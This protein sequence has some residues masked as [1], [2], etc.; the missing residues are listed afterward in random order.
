LGI[1]CTVNPA[2]GKEEAW[3]ITPPPLQKK[4]LV[5]GAGPAGLEAARVLTL[6]GHKVILYEKEGSLGGQL[7]LAWVP[8]YKKE[9]KRLLDYYQRQI[10]KLGI[11]FR[12]QE[13]LTLALIQRQAPD[14]VVLATGASPKIDPV[15]WINRKNVVLAADVIL[16][17]AGVGETV[18]VLG[19]RTVALET[20]EML[21]DQGKKVTIIARAAEIGRDYEATSK[22]FLQRRWTEKKI[23]SMTQTLVK[24]VQAKGVRVDQN[25]QEKFVKAD[26]IV[27][28]W[29][30][31]AENSLL[32]G[33]GI[34]AAKQGLKVYIAGDCIAPRNLLAAI[35]E[36]A[37]VGREI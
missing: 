9:I 1:T 33:L 37:R 14:A 15:P 8:P 5:A 4:I 21:H 23:E 32:K 19:S 34:L 17:K 6:R 28:A 7:N 29:G 13:E 35:H 27:V 2:V 25:G 3:R 26:T 18:V 22:I 31:V 24:E 16:G 11:E 20:A 36:G 10:A 30:M 12:R